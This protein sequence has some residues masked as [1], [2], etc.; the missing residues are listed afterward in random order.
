MLYRSDTKRA[1]SVSVTTYNTVVS[2]YFIVS[3]MTHQHLN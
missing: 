1:T 3:G 2:R